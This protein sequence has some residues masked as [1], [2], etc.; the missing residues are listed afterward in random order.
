MECYADAL[1]EYVGL[2][3]PSHMAA[4]MNSCCSH[5]ATISRYAP[6]A[7]HSICFI[8]CQMNVHVDC[9]IINT[10]TLLFVVCYKNGSINCYKS[11]T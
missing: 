4:D 8:T 6:S 10:M 2:S 7:V 11:E 1:R 3:T 9:H 5:L